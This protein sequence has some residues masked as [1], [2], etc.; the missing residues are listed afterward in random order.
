MNKFLEITRLSWLERYKKAISGMIFCPLFAFLGFIIIRQIET[1]RAISASRLKQIVKEVEL[2][3]GEGKL[4]LQT[5]TIKPGTEFLEDK[6]FSLKIKA[7]KLFRDVQTWQWMEFKVEH[8]T[9]KWNGSTEIKT[10]YTYKPGWYSEI[11]S[12][13]KFAYKN[14]H[15]NPK[16]KKYLHREI[17]Q[18]EVYFG[19]MKLGKDLQNYLLNYQPL[20]LTGNQVKLPASMKIDTGR[21]E[22]LGH[23]LLYPNTTTQ[24]LVSSGGAS[25]VSGT[26][27]YDFS[28]VSYSKEKVFT[29]FIFD[30]KG[31]PSSPM[32]GDT[33]I[34]YW[35]IPKAEYSIIGMMEGNTITGFKDDSLFIHS[36]F[37][38]NAVIHSRFGKF[39]MMLSGK[40]SL[41]EMF[42][43]VENT[44]DLYFVIF[45]FGG[46]LF[47]VGAF[48]FLGNPLALIISWIPFIG[49]VWEKLIFKIMLLCGILTSLGIS[50]Y[51]I[52]K[53]NSISNL[54]LFDLYFMIAVVIFFVI[55]NTFQTSKGNYS[56]T[57]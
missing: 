42:K 32:I 19:K 13:D 30:G 57:F 22:C 18:K 16:H 50:S 23:T 1:E 33:K 4:F 54:N 29:T 10:E 6:E 55:T 52:Y 11:I 24:T 25:I 5:D 31:E 49:E 27:A 43:T 8:E 44:N 15:Q 12:S 41:K 48:M 40:H 20:H 36:E 26:P 2:T 3:P 53:Q 7:V 34:I 51:Y 21:S 46:L 39:G 9:K 37:P 38:N 35:Y 14:G 28:K 47:M 17:T 56:K 45:R